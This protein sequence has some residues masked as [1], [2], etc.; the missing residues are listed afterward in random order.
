MLHTFYILI[1]KIRVKMCNDLRDSISLQKKQ[2]LFIWENWIIFA[3]LRKKTWK[4]GSTTLS[5]RLWLTYAAELSVPWQQWSLAR[6]IFASGAWGVGDVCR[7]PPKIYTFPHTLLSFPHRRH[8]HQI[9]VFNFRNGAARNLLL[10]T[11][12]KPSKKK[13]SSENFSFLPL[14]QEEFEKL[15]TNLLS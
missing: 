4:L 7:Y 3:V 9:D 5:G 15:Q 2:E 1:S 8:S 13:K 6:G 14:I 10:D 11:T 12:D